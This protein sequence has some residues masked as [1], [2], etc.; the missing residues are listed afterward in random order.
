VTRTLILEGHWRNNYIEKG[1]ELRSLCLYK[2][3]FKH[4]K[5]SGEG[6]C[7]WVNGEEYIGEW[8][9]GMRHGQGY[10]TSRNGDETYSGEWVNG[11]VTGYGEYFEKSWSIYKGTFVNFAKMGAG[12]ESFINGDKFEG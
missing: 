2:G 8:K 7:K 4:N 9:N 10:W 1:A 3:T 5:K 12:V 6:E 11:R